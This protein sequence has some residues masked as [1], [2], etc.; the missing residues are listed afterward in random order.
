[1]DGNGNPP[2]VLTILAHNFEE[3]LKED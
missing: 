3:R 1:M 2:D